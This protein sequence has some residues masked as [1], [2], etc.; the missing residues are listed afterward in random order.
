MW[1]KS[2]ET[3][4][5]ELADLASTVGIDRAAFLALVSRIPDPSS[6]NN[7]NQITDEFK[8]R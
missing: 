2:R 6:L 5:Q 3:I 7:G 4:Y 8:V 1:D